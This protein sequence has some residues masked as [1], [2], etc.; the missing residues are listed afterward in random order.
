[1]P[2]PAA[3]SSKPE[4]N[5]PTTT[6]LLSTLSDPSIL[7]PLL[8]YTTSHS[9]TLR[10][11]FPKSKGT[12]T[13]AQHL[14]AEKVPSTLNAVYISLRSLGLV[15][16][17]PT[18]PWGP[19]RKIVET[20]NGAAAATMM[21]SKSVDDGVVLSSPSKVADNDDEEKKEGVEEE[22]V[23]GDWRTPYPPFLDRIFATHLAFTV[24]D[25]LLM[26][27]TQD[28]H[29]TTWIHHLLGLLGVSMMRKL[30][31]A[32][33]FPACFLVTEITLVPSNL[34]YLVQKMKPS[35]ALAKRRHEKLVTAL[36]TIRLV[37]FLVF[38]V[39]AGLRAVYNAI[40]Y[41]RGNSAKEKWESF[42]EK[43]KGMGLVVGG[44]TAFN[45]SVFS[46]MNGYWTFLAMRGL[47]RHLKGSVGNM[48]AGGAAL[49]TGGVGGD[50]ATGDKDI[51]VA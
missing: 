28:A 9:L 10:L 48:V 39:T 4:P 46:V 15:F 16:P 22:T 38:R 5:S 11:L 6:S 37:F 35:S 13:K 42:W 7:L 41:E 26:F 51:F 1:M 34:L 45:L 27:Q 50:I 2:R 18:S 19:L 8:I 49:V 31:T 33:F 40:R 21:S 25:T 17:F 29:P 12:Y 47:R 43:F 20:A 30:K 3:K 14:I 36:L 23:G 24:Y 44:L 32:S